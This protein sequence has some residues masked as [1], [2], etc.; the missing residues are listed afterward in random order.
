[1]FSYVGGK[2]RQADWII[3]QMVEHLD[4]NSVFNEYDRYVEVFGGAM[5]VYINGNVNVQDASYNDYNAQMSNLFS[6]CSKYEEFI[7]Y[8][9][10]NEAQNEERFNKFRDEIVEFINSDGKIEM[11]NFDMASKYVYLITQCFSGIVSE[12]VKFVDLKDKYRSKYYS[13]LDRLK[14]PAI[15]KKLEVLKIYNLSFDDFI[16][17]VDNE[18]TLLYV[19]PPYYGTE[20]LYAFH[21]FTKDNHKKLAD[22]LNSCKGA[23]VLSYYEFPEMHEWYPESK[24]IWVRK[25]YKKGSSA[26]KGKKQTVGTELLIIKK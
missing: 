7:P 13:F 4:L 25:D 1:M 24:Y 6:C 22:L 21:N 18:K 11:P 3:E 20:D 19:D 15:Q 8:L 26:A 14:K 9:E 5:W 2:Y 16:P 23:W 17:E 12:K 10:S